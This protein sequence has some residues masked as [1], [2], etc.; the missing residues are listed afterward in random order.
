MLRSTFCLLLITC[1]SSLFAQTTVRGKVTDPSGLTVIGANIVLKDEPGT[2]TITDLDGLYTLTVQREAP[3]TLVFSF[4]GLTAQEHIVNATDGKTVVLNVDMKDNNVELKTFEVEGK[5]R[6]ASDT[7]LDRLKVNAPVSF[8][9]ISSDAIKKTGD[10]DAGQ[11]IKRVTG[12]STVGAFVTVRGLADRYLVTTVNGARIPTLD[13][14][15]NN[16]RLD[17]F[18]TGLLDNIIIT[19]TLS[20]DMPG[21]WA[22]AYLSLNTT[23]YP[24]SLQ[25]NVGSMIGYNANATFKDIIASQHS[26]TDW[27]GYDDGLRA[28]PDGVSPDVEQ[29][30]DL[31][32]PFLYDQ[33]STLGLSGYLN[34]YGITS[35]TPG[36]QST[37]M[38]LDNPL[39]HLALTQLGLLGAAELNDANAVANA[40]NAYNTTYDLSYFSPILNG[41]LALANKKFNNDNWRLVKKQARPNFS[42][43]FNIGNQLQLFKK[44]K[45]PSTL[46]YLFGLR[47]GT[48]TEHDPSAVQQRSGE[49]FNDT[50]VGDEFGIK[51]VQALTVETNSWSVVGSL[52]FKLDRNNNFTLMVM[53]SR[54]GQNNARYLEFLQPGL[55]TETYV[56]EDQFY[57]QRQLWVYQYGSKHLIPALNL[58]VEADASYSDGDR[59][60]LDMRILQYVK[61]VDGRPIEFEAALAA[62][63]RVYRFMDETMLDARITFELPLGEPKPSRVR[64]LKFGG[65][66]RHNERRNTQA[67]FAVRGAPPPDQWN[68]PGQF[69][70][71]A[72]GRFNTLYTPFGTF[73]DNDIGILDVWAGYVMTD[74]ALSPRLRIVG[75]VRAEHT[76]LVTD[77]LR[78]HEDG[79][80]ADDPARG[81]VGDVAI[82]GAST[83]EPKPAR[84]GTI[85][86]WDI[87]PSVN[88]IH[89][90][91]EDELAPTNLRFGY[92]RSLARPSFREFSV[93]QLYDY[94]LRSFAFGNPDLRM[95]SIDNYDIRLERFF[96]SQNNI[97]LSAFYKR[98]TDHIELLQT[99]AGGFTWRNADLS[100]V[101]GAELEGRVR[102]TRGLEWRGNL[103]WMYSR[104]DIRM[105]STGHETTAETFSTRMFGQAPWLVNA[106]FSYV[107]DSSGFSAS[108]SYNVQGPKLAITNSEIV[109]DATRAYEMPMHLIDITLGQKLGKNWSLT[110]RARNLLNAPLRRSYL[111]ASG[112]DFDFDS[113]A[114]GT[115]Y[116]LGIAYSIK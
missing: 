9:F 97:S 3:F 86:K 78:F 50:D 30:P 36:F 85:Y 1:L 80:D 114:W 14:L 7:Y 75:G 5:A 111:Y 67:Y 65:A 79:L 113:Y 100:R 31:I 89:K 94:Q 106:M 53:P 21:D 81:T 92:F 28:I 90:L 22:G 108:V 62:P 52:G 38:S 112:Y 95:T 32:E 37:N 33:L 4:V 93:V 64:K 24:Q 42:Q 87:L 35:T 41:E 8:D 68:T 99:Q 29:F 83:P 2:G 17:L 103:T 76:D 55:G 51:G 71:R 84:P 115:E 72:D 34:G 110:A 58:T 91:D 11:A 6:R 59:D 26:S 69:D 40:V 48:K 43:T 60:L 61:P 16:L 23:D 107:P 63:G 19:K 98:F 105:G 102:I 77:I 49:P 70:M 12:V 104:S 15:T 101:Y 10:S 18:P 27:L 73:K 20:P 47:Y 44:K 109:T 88:F 54:I 25:V 56:S 66:F 13:P 96:A 57:E 74:F 45:D 46:G 82:Q 39:Q 116:S